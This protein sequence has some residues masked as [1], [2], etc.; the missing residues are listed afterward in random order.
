MTSFEDTLW[1]RLADHG[2]DTAEIPAKNAAPVRAR[3]HLL[4]HPRFLAGGTLGLAGVGATLL[5]ALGGT[6]APPAFA[7]TQKSDGTVFVKFNLSTDNVYYRADLRLIARYHETA[8]I[9]LGN[10]S[11]PVAGPVDCTPTPDAADHNAMP[12]GPPVKLLLGDNGTATYEAGNSGSGTHYIASC[13]LYIASPG[14]RNPGDS[15]SGN[16]GS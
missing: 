10:G 4:R 7:I 2:A 16:T 8:L 3:T 6:A 12:P 11:A 5:L 14:S 1:A 15:D 9:R 13:H